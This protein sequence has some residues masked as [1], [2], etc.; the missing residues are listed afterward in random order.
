[1]VQKSLLKCYGALREATCV[2]E[3]CVLLTI[4][5]ANHFVDVLNDPLYLVSSTK[6]P[7]SFASVKALKFRK[8]QSQIAE[9]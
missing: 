4:R 2:L 8:V 9:Q 7:A 1:M 3:I 5:R 6:I